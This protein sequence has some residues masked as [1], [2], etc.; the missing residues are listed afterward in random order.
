MNNLPPTE[1]T[2]VAS[3]SIAKPS[4]CPANTSH[5]SSRFPRRKLVSVIE[6]ELLP[7]S[8]WPGGK[9]CHTDVTRNA[10]QSRLDVGGPGGMVNELRA[11]PNVRGVDND[12]LRSRVQVS[13]LL[14]VV[15]NAAAV[16]FGG[17]N[18]LSDVLANEIT[19]GRRL[20]SKNSKP[21][22]A[23]PPEHKANA[24][25]DLQLDV[26]T[27]TRPQAVNC[28]PP[29]KKADSDG[30]RVLG[31]TP[32]L[33]TTRAAGDGAVYQAHCPGVVHARGLVVLRAAGRASVRVAFAV[34]LKKGTGVR[35]TA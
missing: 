34:S 32:K 10:Q 35:R 19:T 29:R 33:S 18:Q 22:R 17:C 24:S 14:G 8:Q 7:D 4:P 25:T 2:P 23:G 28:A 16:T 30:T 21:V 20:C 6:E 12:S 13:Q 27:A 9:K 5:C 15:G 1:P 26:A 3:M 11:A 31:S